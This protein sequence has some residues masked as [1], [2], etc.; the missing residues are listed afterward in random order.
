M[1]RRRRQPGGQAHQVG[2]GVAVH[3]EGAPGRA[4]GLLVQRAVGHGAVV[5]ADG[6]RAGGERPRLE[7]PPGV[8]GA[9]TSDLRE[10]AGRGVNGCV[11]TGKMEWNK[12]CFLYGDDVSLKDSRANGVGRF[13][14]GGGRKIFYLGDE[15]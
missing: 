15:V 14:E 7:G 3:G 13:R 9:V 11:Q 5:T 10:R 6:A 8:A 1:R 12:L 2:L 4:G